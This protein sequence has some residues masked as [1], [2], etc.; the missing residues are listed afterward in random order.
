M[1]D[2]LAEILTP[3]AKENQR[4]RK[5][6]QPGAK[7]PNIGEVVDAGKQAAKEAGVSHR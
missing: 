2:T 6:K 1:A 4:E 5:G 7:S 3:K